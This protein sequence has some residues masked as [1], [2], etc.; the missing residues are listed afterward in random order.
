MA[1]ERHVC[2]IDDQGRLSRK[3]SSTA[4]FLYGS[5]ES[6]A[7]KGT[8]C[9]FLHLNNMMLLHVW[10]KRC[11]FFIKYMFYSSWPTKHKFPAVSYWPY[12]LFILSDVLHQWK[13]KWPLIIN[14]AIVSI[15]SDENYLRLLYLL[16][17]KPPL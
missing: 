1:T 13:H 5:L 15:Y 2:K 14:I 16:K 6:C 8:R 10:K 7:K 12:E 9:Y 4:H 3:Y 17:N 11:I